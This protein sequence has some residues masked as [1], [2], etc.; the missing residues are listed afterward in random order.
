MFLSGSNSN[1]KKWETELQALRE[2]NARLVDALQES[3]ANVESW[4]KQLNAC[5]DES[6]ALRLQVRGRLHPEGQT[7]QS[8][9]AGSLLDQVRS[10]SDQV[11]PA[12]QARRTG[13]PPQVLIRL[14]LS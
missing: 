8:A 11:D 9:P 5:K 3:S 4:K 12:L 6:D 7:V 10:G 13:I 1:T 14:T 2:N